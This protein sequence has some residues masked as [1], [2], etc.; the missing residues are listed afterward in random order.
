MSPSRSLR[1]GAPF[2]AALVTILVMAFVAGAHHTDL[3]DPNDTRGKLD[4]SRVRFAHTNLA[5]WTV[6]TFSEWRTANIWDRGY[7][8]VMLDTE[9]GA[10]A[11]YYLLVRSRG[12]SLAGSLWRARNF[13]S[14]TYLGTVPVKRLSRR[15]VTVQVGLF[16]LA[17]GERR[18]FY[19]WW[20]HTVF[21]GDRCRRSCHDRAPRRDAVRQWR[22]GMSPSPSPSPSPSE[23]PSP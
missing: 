13:G 11:E 17:F 10:P 8:M 7:F 6:L 5:A 2:G 22:P 1:V 23:S 3:S 4:V 19:R 12:G 20:V 15:S 9:A 18:T 14:D 21:T 16:R